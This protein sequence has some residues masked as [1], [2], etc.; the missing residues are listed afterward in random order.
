MT[1]KKRSRG[2]RILGFLRLQTRQEIL[3]TLLGTL[4]GIAGYILLYLVRLPSYR[5]MDMLTVQIDLALL[6]IPVAAAFFGPLAGLLVGLLGALGADA[7]F[8]QQ[9]I[10]LGLI[11]LSYGLLGLMT[12]IPHYTEDEG[13]SKGRRLG[14]LILFT[15]AGL[16]VMVVVYLGG[17]LVVAGQN[18]LSTILYNFLPFF[19][20]PLITLVIVAPVVVRLAGILASHVRK[21][22][23]S[24]GNQAGNPEN[25]VRR[26]LPRSPVHRMPSSS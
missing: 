7:L 14:K 25:H 22:G 2:S 12:G 4:A 17:L 21:H 11:D 13:F 15:M 24:E 1:Q 18:L 26:G 8:T 19:S 5:L 23:R 10:A 6:A 20:V 9:I 3:K 16:L